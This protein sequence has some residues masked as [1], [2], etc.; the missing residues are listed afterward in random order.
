[1]DAHLNQTWKGPIKN[2]EYVCPENLIVI[3]FQVVLLS[4]KKKKCANTYAFQSEDI[5]SK[6]QMKQNISAS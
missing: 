3:Y 4:F 1:M 6:N 5:S 2:A